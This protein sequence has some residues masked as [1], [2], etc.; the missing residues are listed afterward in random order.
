[1]YRI[2][3]GKKSDPVAGL[4]NPSAD[5]PKTV[6]YE[7]GIEYNIANQILL[8]VAGYYRDITEQTGNVTYIDWDGTVTYNTTENKNYA[9]VRGFE[10][11]A[12]KRFGRWVT[13]WLQFN[14]MVTTSG[15]IGRNTYYENPNTQRTSGLADPDL[16]RPVARPSASANVRF[17]SPSDFG[18]M[19]AGIY[20]AGDFSV[21]FL[22]N[23]QAGRT[24]TW[25][26]LG[27]QKLVSNLR[28]KSDY[29]VD[30]RIQKRVKISKLDLSLFADITNLLNS[31]LWNSAAFQNNDDHDN[32]LKSLK[33][34][35]YSDPEY[36][37]QY[38][39]NGMVAGDDK[40]GDLSSDGKD[41]IND[42]NYDHLMYLNVRSILLGC[43][44]NL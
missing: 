12:D 24:E 33:L 27:T 16:V 37:D 38:A 41:Y 1:M 20:P 36:K 2:N 11:R 42:P 10:I 19:V 35:M 23:W 3:W 39:A 8:H 26:P 40:A 31:D 43:T 21:N 44:I 32:Y 14:Y 18:P 4:G 7:L 29:T 17:T 13:G 5:L 9:D 28:W 30:L 6:A 34:E 15:D 22:L 25:D